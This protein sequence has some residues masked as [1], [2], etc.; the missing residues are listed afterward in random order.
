MWKLYKL[1]VKDSFAAA[2]TVIRD[3]KVTIIAAATLKLHSPDVLQGEALATLLAV[4]LAVSLGFDCLLLE[5][6]ALLNCGLGH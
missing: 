5:E 6:D 3:D 4:R 1:A 2:A